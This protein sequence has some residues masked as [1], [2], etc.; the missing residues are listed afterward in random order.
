MK[1]AYVNLDLAFIKIKT[2]RDGKL[3]SKGTIGS[4][5]KDDVDW[6]D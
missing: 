1:E 3:K 5:S 2:D 4:D 6:N